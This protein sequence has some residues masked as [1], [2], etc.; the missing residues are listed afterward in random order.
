MNFEVLDELLELKPEA[1]S[2]YVRHACADDHA[3]GAAVEA[4]LDEAD[5]STF[6]ESPA[7]EFALPFM[8]DVAV[9]LDSGPDGFRIGA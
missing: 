8:Q 7:A 9:D 1:R 3:M 4:V 2:A 6:L 5:A